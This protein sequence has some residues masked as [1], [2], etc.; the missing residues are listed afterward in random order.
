L[1]VV[2]A[3]VAILAL[4]IAL[5]PEPSHVVGPTALGASQVGSAELRTDVRGRVVAVV[6]LS[7]REV[8]EAYCRAS[9]DTLVPLTVVAH[10]VPGQRARLGLL[11]NAADPEDVLALT[12]REDR[13]AGGWIAG[14]GSSP[15]VATSAPFGAV[16]ALRAG[17]GKEA[18]SAAA[19]ARLDPGSP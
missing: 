8:L 14:D 10:D 6:A 4:V 11:H 15:L 3:A 13:E 16:R 19:P 9:N 5:K 18:K 7:P 2:V 12:I 17:R 1:V